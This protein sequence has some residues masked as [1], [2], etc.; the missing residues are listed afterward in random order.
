MTITLL[1]NAISSGE[2][3]YIRPRERGLP[4]PRGQTKL[5]NYRLPNHTY[6]RK[7]GGEVV[8]QIHLLKKGNRRRVALHGGERLRPVRYR[9]Q[10][11]CNGKVGR[12]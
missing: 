6:S 4:I 3:N 11:E 12:G 10:Q 7:L 1:T 5:P 9:L 8:E 2:H